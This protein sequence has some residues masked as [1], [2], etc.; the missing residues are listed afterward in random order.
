MLIVKEHYTGNK[1]RNAQVRE[2]LPRARVEQELEELRYHSIVQQQYV[3]SHSKITK[4]K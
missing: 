4:T 2:D 1:S 3:F